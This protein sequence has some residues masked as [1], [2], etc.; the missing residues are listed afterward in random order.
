MTEERGDVA[1]SLDLLRDVAMWSVPV[2]ITVAVLGSAVSHDVRFGTSCVL[3]AAIDIGTL[4][5]TVRRTKDLDPHMAW[6]GGP[7]AYAFLFRVAVKA[8]L[9]VAAVLLP[10][11]LSL[12]GAAVGVLTVDL[13]LATVG[14]A[15]AAWHTLRPHRSGG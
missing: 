10:A 4:A 9:L 6:S 3:G 13:T 14:S 5:W 8:T 11:V 2:A 15:A 12:W 7:L 1:Y